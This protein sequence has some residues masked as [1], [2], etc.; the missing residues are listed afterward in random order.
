MM[1][2][3]LREPLL[4]FALLGGLIFGAYRVAS[5]RPDDGAEI[6]VTTDRIASLSAQ[7][8]VAHQG[9]PPREDELRAAID[10]YVRDEVLYREGLALGLDRDD[11][12][13]RNRVRQKADILSSD[14]LAAEPTERDLQ[15]YLEEHQDDFDIP[16]RISFEQVYFNPTKHGQD[17]ATVIASARQA[18]A[19]DRGTGTLGDRTLLPGTM[20]S[21]LPADITT[22]FGD[23]FEKNLAS[24]KSGRWQGPISSSFG[25]HLV[26]ITWRGQTTR[27]T[28]ADARAVVAREWTRAH[29]ARMK[30]EFYRKLA[31]RYAIRIEPYVNVAQVAEQ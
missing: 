18:L 14:A 19:D 10:A 28:L 21:A 5:P 17:L 24:L 22:A 30:E 26:R 20:T 3:V 8:S 4:H 11:P 27:A 23:A 16:A 7:F 13:V 12:V 2:R 9:R 31:Q 1:R 25:A 29:N 15:I 6:I